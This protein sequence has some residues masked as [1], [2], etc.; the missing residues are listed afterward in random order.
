[1]ANGGEYWAEIYDLPHIGITKRG[2]LDIIRGHFEKM[3]NQVKGGRCTIPGRTRTGADFDLNSL[4]NP[5]SNTGRLVKLMQAVGAGPGGTEVLAFRIDDTSKPYTEKSG[6]QIDLWGSDVGGYLAESSLPNFDRPAADSFDPDHIYGGKNLLANPGAEG[7]LPSNQVI[8]IW[9]DATGGTFTLSDGVDTTSAIAFNAGVTTLAQEI[10]ND[11]AS[12]VDVT[13]TG[14]GTADDP[15]HVE[16]INPTG[17]VPLLTANDAGLTPPGSITR[18]SIVQLGGQLS[19]QSWT[20]SY[21]PSTG[22]PHGQV[23][24]LEASTLQVHSGTYSFRVVGQNFGTDWQGIQQIVSVRSGGTHHGKEAWVWSPSATTFRW[25][26]RTM[27]ETWITQVEQAV[28]ASTWT[29]LVLPPFKVPNYVKQVI[30]R[31][32]PL[33]DGPLT[34]HFDDT[35]FAPGLP[36]ATPGAEFG[37]LLDAFQADGQLTFIGKG[38][39]D[40][41]SS[42]GVPWAI[43]ELGLNYLRGRSM[44]QCLDL[45]TAAGPIWLMNP[46]GSGGYKLDLYNNILEAGIDKSATVVIHSATRAFGTATHR[47]SVP[48]ANRVHVEGA[49]GLWT[50]VEDASKKAGFGARTLYAPFAEV[51]DAATLT[52]LG[53]ALLAEQNA[54]ARGSRLILNDDDDL[55]A[56]QHAT[57][58]DRV[59]LDLPPE[60][61]EVQTILGVSITIAEGRS[62]RAELHMEREVLTEAEAETQAI[63]RMLAKFEGNPPPPPAPDIAAVQPINLP[64]G[65]V[66][67]VYSFPGNCFT[68]E[69]MLE[70]RWPIPVTLIGIS[71]KSKVAPTGAAII[72]DANKN[73]TTI[74]PAQAGRPTIPATFTNS[75]EVTPQVPSF[76]AGDVLR[77]DIDQVGSTIPGGHL[78]VMLRFIWAAT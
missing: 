15:W 43:T 65:G 8:S 63:L 32:S 61:R 4:L 30:V 22:V 57:F 40:T 62:A 24:V 73:G 31:L 78:T 11:I 6:L 23:T 66:F 47:R 26:V 2:E 75:A 18:I 41:H 33:F 54:R 25:V 53:T 74:F 13:V 3:V 12:I 46:N 58:C 35:H 51:G 27:D 68:H 48:K 9:N 20:V 49:N 21:N 38:F 45:A 5:T 17:A 69:G 52:T 1:M 34:W 14:A 64:A 70:I 44:K 19:E 77:F 39:T 72:V 10:E 50:V 59:T 16:Y 76:A 60:P 28:S 56:L 67:Q 71:L 42:A 37:D 55:R 29:K 7:T 36:A